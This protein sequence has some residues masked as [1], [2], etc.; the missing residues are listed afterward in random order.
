MRVVDALEAGFRLVGRRIWLILLPVLLDLFLWAGPRLSVEPLVDQVLPVMEELWSGQQSDLYAEFSP[1]DLSAVLSKAAEQYNLFSTLRWA[2]VGMPSLLAERYALLNSP[3]EVLRGYVM[4]LVL[5]DLMI[6]DPLPR[7]SNTTW[8]VSS[9]WA[10]M[11]I[12]PGLWIV[13]TLIAA[14]YLTALAREVNPAN[15]DVPWWRH[16]GQVWGSLLLIGVGMG[17]LGVVLFVPASFLFG[18]LSMLNVGVAAFA[19]S[20]V[21]GGVLWVALYL[22]YLVVAVAVD[23]LWPW[24]AAW[25]SA[26]LVVR[27]FGAT[28]G[29]YLLA[30]LISAGLA[31][32]WWRLNTGGV[33][34]FL[35]MVG[36]AYVGTSLLSGTMIFYYSRWRQHRSVAS[37]SRA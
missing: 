18:L 3:V 32:A 13:G 26:L 12:W 28:L 8:Y 33:L 31:V 5:G 20:L 16:V 14:V 29:L 4:G 6:E 37:G 21:M 19:F 7:S 15:R 22:V 24:T 35:A 36:N 11:L 30:N 2:P 10:W 17:V 1:E 23:R 9:I 27:Y 25:R 34:S